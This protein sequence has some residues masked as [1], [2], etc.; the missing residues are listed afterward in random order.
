MDGNE[1]DKIDEIIKVLENMQYGSLQITVH[2]GQITQIDKTEKT[3]Y[4]NQK[5]YRS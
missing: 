4:T 3:R 1:Q 5:S 2:N